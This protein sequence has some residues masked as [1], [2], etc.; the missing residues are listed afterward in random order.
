MFKRLQSFLKGYFTFTSRER[1]GIIVLLSILLLVIIVPYLWNRIF[2]PKMKPLSEFEQQ[3]TFLKDN[4]AN[5]KKADSS[6]YKTNSYSSNEAFIIEINSADSNSF[7]RVNGIKRYVAARIIKYR[8]ALGGFYSVSQLKEVYGLKP[9]LI[10][11]NMQHF[12]VDVSRLKTIN[13]NSADINTLKH[14]PYIGN[15]LANVI[16]QYRLQHGSFNS[17]A[18]LKK[19]AIITDEEYEKLLPYITV[20]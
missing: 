6:S 2:P 10:D 7:G 9:E 15:S 4:T 5:E 3:V 19:I 11:S 18:D 16:V 8:R 1:R 14:H 17:K 20:Q 12:T 13:I